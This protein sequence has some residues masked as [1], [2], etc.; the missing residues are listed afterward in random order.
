MPEDFPD[1]ASFSIEGSDEAIDFE[2]RD[3]GGTPLLLAQAKTRIEPGS[4]SASELLALARRWAEADPGGNAILRFLS[5]APVHKSGHGLRHLISKAEAVSDPHE[6][7]NACSDR[8]PSGVELEAADHS[9]FRRLEIET[10]LGPWNQILDQVKV[11]ILRISGVALAAS[12]VD[13][14]VH[15]LFVDAFQR[16]SE[17]ELSRR[18]ITLS[19]LAELLQPSQTIPVP[20]FGENAIA[21]GREVRQPISGDRASAPFEQATTLPPETLSPVESVEWRPGR[22]NL[23]TREGLFVGRDR[24]LSLIDQGLKETGAGAAMV[25]HGLGGIGK[26]TLVAQWATTRSRESLPVWWITADTP[27]NLDA[28]LAALA[29]SL[30][31]ALA[32]ALPHRMLRDWAVEWLSAHQEWLLILDNVANPS[33]VRPLLAQAP[34]GQFLITSRRATGW[35]GVATPMTLDALDPADA[36]DLFA[37]ILT[38]HQVRDV[39]GTE[40][41]CTELGYLPLA[42]E[43]VAAF[44][45]ETATSPRAYLDLLVRYPAHLYSTAAE[46]GDPQRTI[47]RIWHLTLDRLADDPLT[48][49]ILRTLAWYAPEAIP[50]ALVQKFGD[51]PHVLRALGRLAAHSMLTLSE[52]TGTITMHRLVQAVA[53][54][55]DPEDPHRHPDDIADARTHASAFLAGELPDG[56]DNPDSWPAWNVFLPHIDALVNHVPSDHDTIDTTYILSHAAMFL[57]GKGMVERAT[58]YLH[59]AHTN[60]ARIL[61]EDHPE[62]LVAQG[63]LAVSYL[64]SGSLQRAI[65]LFETVLDDH[66]RALGN[67]DPNTLRARMNLAGAYHAAGDLRRATELY[68]CALSGQINTLGERHPHVLL[69]RGN[70]ALVY[71]EAGDVER[72]IKLLERTCTDRSQALGKN[73]PDTL[74]AQ[75]NLAGAY[76]AAGDLGRAVAMNESILAIQ[77][78]VL[79]ADH[80]DTLLSRNN[81][82]VASFDA[83]NPRRAVEL[84]T[85]VV[86]DRVRVLGESHFHTMRARFNLASAYAELGDLKRAIALYEDVL[87]DQLLTLG[88]NHPDVLLT[89]GNLA[90]AYGESGEL[91]RAVELNERAPA[92]HVRILGEDH[93]GTLVAR[94]SLAVA[95][96]AAG[97]ISRATKLIERLHHD[98]ARVMGDDHPDT[99]TVRSLLNEVDD[100]GSAST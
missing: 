1:A 91:K 15:R 22:T 59:R 68:E 49:Q 81:L 5:D 10:R 62:T 98:Y 35:H 18:T 60:C 7:L 67:E 82:A 42:L 73:H 11:E 66:I 75:M 38:H 92:D 84:L 55:P 20:S 23:P 88:E 39:D 76:R 50:R 58:S 24:E 6:W 36:G 95:C 54:T 83:G 72:A 74:R 12:E 44:C 32:D 61:G 40:Q 52:D 77:L 8:T 9:L 80:P 89:L 16:S 28:G 43:Q 51:H 86:D 14:T 37:R 34:T 64:E 27:A 69:S 31:P 4:W 56:C 78:R 2:I 90:S 79:G 33:D 47:A 25:V 65:E 71:Q 19:D 93:P 97:D 53:R 17:P 45:A 29:V 21:A 41:V 99:Q 85:D 3:S 63:D 94:G 57:L 26:S 100:N 96:H 30:Q 87:N 48:G 13:A 70:L 46:G